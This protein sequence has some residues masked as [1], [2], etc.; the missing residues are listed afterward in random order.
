[1]IIVTVLRE[2]LFHSETIEEK[3]SDLKVR[4]LGSVLYLSRPAAYNPNPTQSIEVPHVSANTDSPATFSIQIQSNKSKHI[5]EKRRLDAID[6]KA[7]CTETNCPNNTLS[8]T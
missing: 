8:W 4:S 6:N 5:N 1:M 7:K 2:Q 3:Q